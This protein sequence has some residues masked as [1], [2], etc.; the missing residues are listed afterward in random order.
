MAKFKKKNYLRVGDIKLPR[1]PL[2]ASHI[3][4]H[5]AGRKCATVAIKDV[6]TLLGV[7]GKLQYL[8][9]NLKTKKLLETH[10]KKYMWDGQEVTGYKFDD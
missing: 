7:E 6:D 8:R 3:K 10:A 4:I 5:C 2:H 9:L 1:P